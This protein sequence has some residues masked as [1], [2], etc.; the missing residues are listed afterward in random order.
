[1]VAFNLAELD[2]L[3]R[4]ERQLTILAAVIVLVMAGGVAADVS[5]GVRPSR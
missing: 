5:S 2:K 4:R 1:M 3:E